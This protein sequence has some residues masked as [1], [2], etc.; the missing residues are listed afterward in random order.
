MERNN[1][2]PYILDSEPKRN[3]LTPFSLTFLQGLQSC[4]TF[5]KTGSIFHPQRSPKS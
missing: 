3:V 1:P 5:S 4:A 2:N